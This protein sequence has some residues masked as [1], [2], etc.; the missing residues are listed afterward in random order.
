MHQLSLVAFYG[1]KDKRLLD[2]IGECQKRVGAVRGI[3]FQ[4]YDV[5]QIHGT[6]VCLARRV[7]TMVNLNMS[8]YRHRQADMDFAGLLNFIR[9]G[10]RFP[11]QVQIG[12]FQNR[13]YA[14]TSEGKRPYERSFQA[15][16]GRIVLIGWPVRGCPLL[17][18][19]LGTMD[20]IQEARIYPNALDD[21]RRAL[22]AFNILHRYHSSITD[23][24]NDFYFRI[25]IL[26]PTSV[27][28]ESLGKLQEDV[29]AY[30]SS[31]RPIILEVGIADLYV[32][33][34][35]NEEL[36]LDSTRVWSVSDEEVT[37]T[38]LRALYV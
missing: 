21:I 20:L 28:S 5:R 30:L 27:T 6:I 26:D 4:P 25:G 12:G 38:F 13:D 36:P 33:C 14:F 37:P 17:A 15:K 32:A 1:K 7:G 23:T 18:A 8:K 11:F 35:E 3:R 16:G 22:Q 9:M 24:D 2:L 19:E 10:G 29:R 34:Y 31:I